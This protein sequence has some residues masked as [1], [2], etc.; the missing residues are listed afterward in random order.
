MRVRKL[1]AAKIIPRSWSD[2]RMNATIPNTHHPA[3]VDTMLP[4]AQ[5][6]WI[7]Y[8]ERYPEGEHT[9]VGDLRVLPDLH[10]PQLGNRR[11]L[12]ALL[13]AGYADSQVRYPTL[14]MHDGQNLFDHATS[15]AGEWRVD[16]T[17]AALA[18]EGLQAI[19]VGVPN[20]GEARHLEYNPNGVFDGEPG[21]GDAYLAF[22]VETVKPR[23]DAAF[24]TRPEREQ[25]GVLGSS[26]GGWIS[27][28][29]F[30][31]APKT[32]GLA[33]ALSP[34]LGYGAR[35]NF[36]FIERAAAPSGRIYLDVG[37]REA[38]N[39]RPIWLLRGFDSW[40]YLRHVRR[41]RRLL[42]AKG[43]RRGM[44]LHWV[45]APGAIHHEDEWA[46]RLPEALR[47]LLGP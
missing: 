43:Y 19:V 9:V 21:R 4:M 33:G 32:F 47:F 24:R 35:R 31:R 29:A 15:F 22:L 18:A 41:T 34:Y 12:L 39:M 20:A 1:D 27:L 36:A 38:W 2:S 5:P 42:E 7:A 16:E 26:L 8:A 14:Y 25:T 10:S 11:D 28:Y 3:A 37:T 13:P 30:F 17:M 40:R 23:I 45:E 6:D 44:N 46:R